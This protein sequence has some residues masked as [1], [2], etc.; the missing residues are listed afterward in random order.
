[1]VWAVKKCRLLEYPKK[2]LSMTRDPR[3]TWQYFAQAIIQE[4]DPAKLTHL[5]QELYR[6][7]KAKDDNEE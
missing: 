7:L 1:M 4:E 6:V 2:Q 5:M 3:K